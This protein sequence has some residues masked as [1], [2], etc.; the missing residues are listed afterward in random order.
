MQATAK[1][2]G[3]ARRPSFR[4]KAEEKVD[5]MPPTPQMPLSRKPSI[6]K[7]EAESGTSTLTRRGSL[8]KPVTEP[9]SSLLTRRPSM[10]RDREESERI[11]KIQA[12]PS[13]RRKEFG[14]PTSDEKRK[15]AASPMLGRRKG[16]PTEME[17][18]KQRVPKSPSVARREV[19]SP[20]ATPNLRRKGSI[21]HTL[22]SLRKAA[23][24]EESC[25]EKESLSN[26]S[27][28]EEASKPPPLKRSGSLRGRRGGDGGGGGGG[29]GAKETQVPSKFSLQDK[30]IQ[31]NL[32]K[33]TSSKLISAR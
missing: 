29:G 23:A 19:P 13:L 31:V 7:K 2:A 24:K 14:L 27:G 28:N 33:I 17:E 18:E 5:S 6:G 32:C 9:T 12:S 10:R 3:L 4:E 30:F 26:M 20:S 22:E 11:A 16:S 21:R 15:V 1:A 25:A 8:R